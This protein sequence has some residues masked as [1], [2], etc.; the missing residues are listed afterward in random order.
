MCKEVN[1]P[2]KRFESAT[3]EPYSFAYIDKTKRQSEKFQ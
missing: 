1:V 3:S 2:K